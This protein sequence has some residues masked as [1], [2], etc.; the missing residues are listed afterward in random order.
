MYMGFFSDMD[1]MK[2]CLTLLILFMMFIMLFMI[3]SMDVSDHLGKIVSVR[4]KAREDKLRLSRN[5]FKKQTEQESESTNSK[6]FTFVESNN[7]S[8]D[9]ISKVD[10]TKN[11]L[12]DKKFNVLLNER[13]HRS[14]SRQAQNILDN[15]NFLLRGKRKNK[16][17]FFYKRNTPSNKTAIGINES[18]ESNYTTVFKEIKST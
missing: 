18:Q 10:E 17:S 7:N 13:H 15:Q 3:K 16:R 4:E 6:S 5:I 1:S 8:M 9:K 14:I 12:S 2:M 11:I